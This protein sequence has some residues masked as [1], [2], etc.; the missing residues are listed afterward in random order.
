MMKYYIN[1]MES[2]LQ[3][4]QAPGKFGESIGV[5]G[6]RKAEDDDDETRE[7]SSKKVRPAFKPS[8]SMNTGDVSYPQLNTDSSSAFSGRAAS[9]TKGSTSVTPAKPSAETNGSGSQ[10][11]NLFGNL[12]NKGV[13]PS[14]PAAPGNLFSNSVSSGSNLFATP[15]SSSATTTNFFAAAPSTIPK[16]TSTSLSGHNN[17]FANPAPKPD[18]EKPIQ[19]SN[20]FGNF[21][22][23]PGSG[24]PG[25]AFSAGGSGASSPFGAS[26]SRAGTVS[27]APSTTG[28]QSV[29]D[30]EEHRQ[31][32]D[33]TNLFAKFA[34]DASKSAE[35]P[36]DDFSDE[37]DEDA[38][39]EEATGNV[40]DAS[41]TSAGG[42]GLFSKVKGR[43]DGLFGRVSFGAPTGGSS[44]GA[45]SF[46]TPSR[47][48][49]VAT[50][51]ADESAAEDSGVGG[52]GSE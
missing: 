11:S 1:V 2:I 28:G 25:M 37:N 51:I 3:G 39:S 15:T 45:T 19:G 20:L 33:P 24:T 40:T 26:L 48:T 22:S 4:G 17:L 43:S 9:P 46:G 21:L 36:D 7:A 44:L 13:T 31:T 38:E 8:T 32:P 12:L 50:S 16:A 34:K 23:T 42:G 41:G 5:G 6:K 29:F 49:S 18:N 35:E 30:S 27:P 14:K 47:A 10:T 52:T